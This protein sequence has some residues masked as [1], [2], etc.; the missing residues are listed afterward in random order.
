VIEAPD[1]KQANELINQ[2]TDVNLVLLDLNLPDRDGFSALVELRERYPTLP[3]IV[4]SAV[5]DRENVVRALEIGALGFIPKSEPREVMLG[6]M[7]LVISGGIY[8]P[9][10]ALPGQTPKYLS[11][12]N[13]T[14]TRR[15]S[16]SFASLG[17]TERQGEVLALI[18]QGKSNKAICRALKLAEPTVKNHVTAIFRALNVSNRT[19]AAIAARNMGLELPLA[20]K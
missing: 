8:I 13:E 18:M 9:P 17:L 14:L 6:A 11:A 15:S 16:V 1:F 19:E 5:Q 10:Q 2:H 7:Q 20:I 3:V 12:P 4:L